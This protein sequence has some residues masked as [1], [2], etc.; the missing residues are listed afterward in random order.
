MKNLK[1]KAIFSV[2]LL[3]LLI[4]TLMN[5]Q[6]S[7]ELVTEIIYSSG[8]IDGYIVYNIATIVSFD[9]NTTADNFK[10]GFEV[11]TTDPFT[12]QD[13]KVILHFDTS[14]IPESA[15]IIAAR[16]TVTNI[17]VDGN[18][19]TDGEVSIEIDADYFGD[20]VTIENTPTEHDGTADAENI[21]TFADFSGSA[22]DTQ[23]VSSDFSTSS[24]NH[25]SKGTNATTQLRLLI[26]DTNDDDF[27]TIYSGNTTTTTFRPYLTVE[28][29][30]DNG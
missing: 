30:I 24:L 29:S 19:W 9:S 26:T 12:A 7:P 10:F 23:C 6:D 28:Y 3:A 1:M 22:L 2:L 27:I 18:P 11:L 17:Q 15:D 14:I 21:A 8:T 16:L 5:C 25:I 4:F 13:Y 20:L